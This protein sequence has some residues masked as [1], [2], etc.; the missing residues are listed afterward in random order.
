MSTYWTLK[1]NVN[2]PDSQTLPRT[3]R[4]RIDNQARI[5]EAAEM[6]FAEAGYKGASMVSIA[7]RA[8]LPRANV[9]YYFNNKLEL[10]NRLLLDILQLW[11]TAFSQITAEDDP[12]EAIGAYI[13]AKVMYSKTNPRASRIFASE[14]IQGAPHL[15]EYLE[16]DFRDWLRGKSRVIDAWAAQGKIDP[17]DPLVLIFLIWSA[18]QHYADFS[19]QVVSV[20]GDRSLD[21]VD[22][23]MV[24]ANL[25]HIILKGC[26]MKPPTDHS[27]PR[28]AMS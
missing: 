26:G 14:I 1:S 7:K 19:V 23:E 20:L 9:H 28:L 4:I 11:N 25:T 13:R 5:I 8:G 2:N 16:T 27:L 17:V 3:G 18:T 15:S 21:E 10:Y 12:A 6:E 22:F 24:A